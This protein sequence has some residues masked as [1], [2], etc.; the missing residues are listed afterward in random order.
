MTADN[1]AHVTNATSIPEGFEHIVN[2]QNGYGPGEQ[3][4]RTTEGLEVL[5]GPLINYRGMSKEDAQDFW[6]GS[7]LIVTKPGQRQPRL[8]LKPAAP[9]VS[10]TNR[11]AT[12]GAKSPLYRNGEVVEGLNLYSDSSKAFWRFFLKVPL[13][14]EES[15]WE[16][17]IPEM[18]DASGEPRH[19]SRTFV[20]PSVHDSMRI[21]FHSCNG[22]SVGTDE[23]AWSGPALWNSVLRIHKERP[24]HIM[25]GGGDQV[26]PFF[27]IPKAV[28]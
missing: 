3:V 20:V 5:C 27:L 17:M 22:F 24:F 25:I 10:V 21:M 19:A 12:S 15:R 18:L 26:W 1:T 13:G 6:H 4:I 16:Y 2:P 7:V 11:T 28:H 23:E 9:A 14:Q 8:Q